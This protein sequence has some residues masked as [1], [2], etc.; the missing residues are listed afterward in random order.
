MEDEPEPARFVAALEAAETRLMSAATV[1]EASMIIEAR[2]GPDGVR[3]LDLLLSKASVTVVPVDLEQAYT[4]R[5]AFRE[6]GKGRHPAA[7][8]F[9]DC[10]V[11]ALAR[12][13]EEAI[14]HKGD[15]FTR[16]DAS[17]VAAG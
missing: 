17:T 2:R 15:D 10:F 14:L 11:Y 4:A 7:L 5:R 8:S 1:L 9:G 6:Y 12:S 16:T 13:A 3:D